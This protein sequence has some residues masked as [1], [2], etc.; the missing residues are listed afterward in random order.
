MIFY[1]YVHIRNVFI[2]IVGMYLMCI[3]MF[4]QAQIVINEIMYDPEGTDTGREWVEVYNSGNQNVDLVT[5]KI[6]ENNV[7]HKL[8]LISDTSTSVIEP[9]EYA[10]LADNAEKFLL[11]YPDFSGLLFDSAFSLNNTG[12]ILMINDSSGV[13]VDHFEYGAELGAGNTGNSLQRN[14]NGFWIDA[15]ATPGTTNKQTTEIHTEETGSTTSG[16]VS[17]STTTSTHSGQN[18]LVKY[19]QKSLLEIGFGRNRVASIHTPLNFKAEYNSSRM[20]RFTWNFGDGAVDRGILGR[21]TYTHPGIYNVLLNA[22]LNGYQ[23]T[24]RVKVHIKPVSV[25]NLSITSGKHVDV[26]LKNKSDTEVNLGQF[27]LMYG[28]QTF[29]I[30]DDTI[31]DASSEITI[32]HT[33]TRFELQEFDNYSHLYYPNGEVLFTEEIL[34]PTSTPPQMI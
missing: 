13:T 34:I 21:H 18:E 1:N 25:E 28:N 9:N 8:I 4:I 16:S 11:D 5:Y 15:K 14:D 10:I 33:H 31:I 19:V 12:E 20:P 30:P 29:V 23:A 17:N 26:L 3:P 27:I 32:P 2:L 6:F 7:N 24:A 22:F